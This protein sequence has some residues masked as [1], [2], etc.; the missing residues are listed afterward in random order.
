MIQPRHLR[1]LVIIPTLQAMTRVYGEKV[2]S[3]AAVNL[4]LGTAFQES[5][6]GHETYLKQIGG[7]PALGI[8]QIEPATHDDIYENYLRHRQDRADFTV[9][10][11]SLADTD[12]QQTIHEALIHNL[13]YSTV[14]ARTKYWRRRFDWPEDPTNIQALGVIWNDHYNA[15]PEHGFPED[16]VS[17]F[18]MGA[19]LIE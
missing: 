14:I 4:L 16:F 1:D 13:R 6:I 9:G 11:L 12:T 18:P 5:V 8:Y 17:A 3:P 15:N 19:M 10:F 2:Y 7:G